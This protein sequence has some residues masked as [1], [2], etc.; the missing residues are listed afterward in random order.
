[1][2]SHGPLY[3]M[4]GAHPHALGAMVGLATGK[5]TERPQDILTPQVI[6][7]FLHEVWGSIALDPCATRDPRNLV[8][9]ANKIYGPW[10]AFRGGLDIPWVDKTYCNPPYKALRAWLEK[11]VNEVYAN[12][13]A[14][15]RIAVLA[16]T[17]GHRVWWHEVRDTA[18]VVLELRPLT[19]VGYPGAFPAPLSLLLWNGV[20]GEQART[21]AETVGLACTKIT[22]L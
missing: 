9:A 3:A 4:G 18:H 14:T 21:A 6:V 17:R 16:P 13:G 12:L 5:K 22:A 20:T 8:D 19:F 7:D 11:A 1:M 2:T 10:G 15:P